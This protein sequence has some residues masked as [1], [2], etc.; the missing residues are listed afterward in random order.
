MEYLPKGDSELAQIP[1]APE[2]QPVVQLPSKKQQSYGAIISVIL[3]MLMI[4]VGAFYAWGK[5]IN[6]TLNVPTSSNTTQMQ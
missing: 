1:L 6:E 5:R 4:V 2:K 3:I